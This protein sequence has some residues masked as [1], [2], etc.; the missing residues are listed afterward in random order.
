MFFSA[1]YMHIVL[2]NLKNKTLNVLKCSRKQ[3][4]FDCF[5]V[6]SEAVH[7][8][9]HSARRCHGCRRCGGRERVEPEPGG[10]ERSHVREVW[11][12]DQPRRCQHGQSVVCLL[13]PSILS[14]VNFKMYFFGY[15]ESEFRYARWKKAVEKSKNWETTQPVANGNGKYSDHPQSTKFTWYLCFLWKKQRYNWDICLV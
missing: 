15:V 14:Y 4:G 7:A 6:C 5:T 11:A 10:P 2:Y 3:V 12:S 13:F 8:W 9:D 1:L